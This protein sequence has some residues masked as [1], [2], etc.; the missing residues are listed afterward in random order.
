MRSNPVVVSVAGLAVGVLIWPSRVTGHMGAFWL[1]ASAF[2]GSGL[3]LR[4]C[5]Q[6]AYT[7]RLSIF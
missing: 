7:D 5:L 4:N 6:I 2:W 1:Q 3:D